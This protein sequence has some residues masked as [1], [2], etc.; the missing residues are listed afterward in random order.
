MPRS[1]SKTDS[2]KGKKGNDSAE[3]NVR[4]RPDS[5]YSQSSIPSTQ[6]RK[7]SSTGKTDG[8]DARK[9]IRSGSLPSQTP[10]PCIPSPELTDSLP[11]DVTNV[12]SPST[13]IALP[14]STETCPCGISDYSVWKI[15]CSKCGRY[16]HTSCLKIPDIS[17]DSINKIVDYL[18][19]FCYV[20]PV[21]NINAA[22]EI[23]F[24]CKNT[25][26][27]RNLALWQEIQ[28]I[29]TQTE[30]LKKASS[31]FCKINDIVFEMISS[32]PDK[33]IIN[34]D[35]SSMKAI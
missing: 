21:Q 2:S 32:Q 6:P 30:N 13:N 29:S 10:M 14:V 20:P 34:D 26:N 3:K 5:F 7:D 12:L 24:S 31:D 1:S 28:L 8:E 15:D 18:C 11:I 16:W 25:K 4:S 17:K 19:P 27:L 35:K 9:N 22:P 23:C 33:N